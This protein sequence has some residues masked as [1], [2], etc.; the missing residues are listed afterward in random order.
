VGRAIRTD[1]AYQ[2]VRCIIFFG[3]KSGGGRYQI[4]KVSGCSEAKPLHPS[5]MAP[6]L[7]AIDRIFIG[8]FLAMLASWN[9]NVLVLWLT[10]LIFIHCIYASS[11][12]VAFSQLNR[13]HQVSICIYEGYWIR[14]SS[15]KCPNRPSAAKLS[16][17]GHREINDSDR[18][19][20]SIVIPTIRP[21]DT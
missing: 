5:P 3:M 15:T 10:F 19:C 6:L 2:H 17:A 16:T 18:H 1:H 7:S 14:S 4:G 20:A 11:H 21:L 8:I 12:R 13:S 9:S